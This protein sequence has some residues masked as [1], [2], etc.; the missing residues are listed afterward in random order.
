MLLSGCLEQK[1]GGLKLA[2]E[3]SFNGICTV[4]F[5]WIH[6]LYICE[7]VVRRARQSSYFDRN[8]YNNLVRA[9]RDCTFGSELFAQTL[10]KKSP[11]LG[12]PMGKISKFKRHNSQKIVYLVFV[13]CV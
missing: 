6:A 1:E 4:L 10:V 12:R 2:V 3:V 13:L 9:I 8:V 5:L 7:Q 11:K